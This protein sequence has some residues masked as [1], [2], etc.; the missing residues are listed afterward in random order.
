MSKP[1][2]YTSLSEALQ[3]AAHVEQLLAAEHQ[4]ITNRLSWLFVSQSFCI[5]A[6]A[7]L[8]TS[9]GNRFPG[10]HSVEVLR[11]GLP[12]LGIACSVLVGFAVA[13][14][15][16]VARGLADE[17][18][19][20]TQYVNAHSPANIALVGASRALRSDRWTYLCGALPHFILPWL[21]GALWLALLLRQS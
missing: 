17:R 18:A 8:V 12:I 5:T 21:P 4:W 10:D 6:Y 11:L 1:T 7:I 3:V 9:S 15:T 19:R 13:A 20:L 2:T 16:H 14:A